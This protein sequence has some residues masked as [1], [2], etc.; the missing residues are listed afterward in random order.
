MLSHFSHVQLFAT[1][2]TVSHQA[3]LSVGFSRQE[4]WNGKPFP[5]PGNLPNPEIEP[6]SPALV[7]RFF[8]VW[9]TRKDKTICMKHLTAVFPGTPLACLYPFWFWKLTSPSAGCA[10]SLVSQTQRHHKP[11]LLNSP[12][13]PLGLVLL[14]RPPL[15]R[16]KQRLKE[17]EEGGTC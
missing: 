7:S 13:G 15:W 6:E 5:S 9:A 16:K 14:I 17:E 10:L 3:P 2:C 4:Y 11:T 1:L 12:S 8:T